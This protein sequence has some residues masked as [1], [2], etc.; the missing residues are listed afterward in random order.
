MSDIEDCVVSAYCQSAI[1]HEVRI[2]SNYRF[3]YFL[4]DTSVVY[5]NLSFPR[6][7]ILIGFY[8]YLFI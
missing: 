7:W 8:I 1:V 5:N 2:S 4:T 3:P 6:S